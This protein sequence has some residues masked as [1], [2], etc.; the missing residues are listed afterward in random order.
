[1]MHMIWLFGSGGAGVPVHMFPA[2]SRCP[3][4]AGGMDAGQSVSSAYPSG[5][6]TS[7]S[8]CRDCSLDAAIGLRNH[9]RV[10]ATS[11]TYLL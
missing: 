11:H 1:M 9:L 2:G 3:S 7:S 4:C 8:S 5:A 10:A 6:T